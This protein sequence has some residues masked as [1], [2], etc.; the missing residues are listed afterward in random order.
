MG[1][2][3]RRQ[4]LREQVTAGLRSVAEKCGFREAVPIWAGSLL[5]L[6]RFLRLGCCGELCGTGFDSLNLLT[7]YV[8]I[9]MIAEPLSPTPAMFE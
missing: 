3:N 4:R 9:M 2:M 6:C 5:L 8:D 7:S 1:P